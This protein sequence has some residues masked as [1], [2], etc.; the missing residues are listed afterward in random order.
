MLEQLGII[1]PELMLALLALFGQLAAVFCRSS[2]LITTIIFILA[3]CILFTSLEG[4]DV[5]S[6]EFDNSF[7]VDKR[8]QL[9]KSFVLAVTIVTIMIYRD[10][11]KI[12][13]EELKIEFI[14][15]MLL[16]TLGIFISISSFN[17]LLLFCGLE[18]QALCGYS[19]AAFNSSH[20]KSSEAGLKYFILGALMSCITLFGISFIY[21]F[22]GSLQFNVLHDLLNQSQS[23][24][25]GLVLG[26]V[27]VLAGILFKLSAAPF[28]N[29]TP[30]VY[31]GA[32]VVSVTYFATAQ[33]I[34]ALIVL[35]NIIILV[36]GD[37][38]QIS[39][40]LIRIVAM[41]S[42]IIGA[43]GAIRQNSLKRLMGYSTILN[44][45]YVLIGVTLHTDSGYH[46]AKLYLMIYVIAVVGFFAC[47]IGSLGSKADDATFEDIIGSA[48]TRK[49]LSAAIAVIMFSMIGLPP[50][51]GFFGKYYLF[52]EAIKGGEYLLAGVGIVTSIVAAYYYLKVIKAMYFV[53]NSLE[54]ERIPTQT[55]L[56]IITSFSIIYLLGFSFFTYF[57]PLN[58]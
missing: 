26:V 52:Y 47:L 2:K 56:L 13:G 45:G 18:L 51:A 30:D 57:Q 31:E 55:G 38:R 14:T 4:T 3:L 49:A 41:L 34:G 15:L 44:V 33:K 20:Y 36:I 23:I 32:P 24:S 6:L 46:V 16:S 17:F 48:S 58:P 5:L 22:G 9:F 28:H 1:F 7:G 25:I 54:I 19:M 12:S 39:V 53:E 21:G 35:L 50:F 27:F 10:Y 40:D 43:F 8:T 42:M 37:Y 11:S 29:W